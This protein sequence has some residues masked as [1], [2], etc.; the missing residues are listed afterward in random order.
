MPFVY[1][2]K[3]GALRSFDTEQTVGAGAEG[4]FAEMTP[5]VGDELDA[6]LHPPPTPEQQIEAVIAA[7]LQIVSTSTPSLNGTYG[8]GS[9]EQQNISGIAAGIASRN[10]LPGGGATFNYGDASGTLHAFNGPNFLNLASAVE[11]YLYALEQGSAPTQPITI[12]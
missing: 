7:G 6:I 12:A 4:E 1:R 8:I 3:D 5:V 11:D 2:D 10:R 9:A